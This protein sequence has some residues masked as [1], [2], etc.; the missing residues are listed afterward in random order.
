[1]KSNPR[2]ICFAI[3]RLPLSLNELLRMHWRF[4]HR[5]QKMFDQL[6][7]IQWLAHGKMVFTEPVRLVYVLSFTS[8]QRRDLDN[9]IGG[10]KLITDALKRTFLFR[11]DAEYIKSIEVRFTKGTEGTAIFIQEVV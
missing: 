9:Y 2:Q 1:V 5:M 7:H 10:T 11:D 4:R 6:V 3:S 8:A